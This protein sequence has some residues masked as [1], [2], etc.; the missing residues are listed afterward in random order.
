MPGLLLPGLLLLG[1][2][3]RKA[4]DLQVYD[5]II[6]SAKALAKICKHLPPINTVIAMPKDAN[7]ALSDAKSAS[8]RVMAM[9][10][11]S[12]RYLMSVAR[13]G[14]I[15]AASNE[16]NIAQ[17]AVSR[18][19]QA[20]EYQLGTPLFERKPRG[21]ALTEAGELLYSFC[22]NSTFAIERLYSEIDELKG[23]RRGRVR[24][25]SMESAVPSVLC[26]AI[27]AFRL[28]HPD[29]VFYVDIWTSDK[30][31]EAVRE[32]DVDIGLTF[33]DEFSDE[34]QVAYNA[35]EPLLAT[36]SPGHP[37]AQCKSLTIQELVDWPLALTPPRS[38]SRVIF[39]RAC[40]K[41]GI[42]I[43]PALETNSIELMHRFALGGAGVTLLIRHAAMS[44][45]QTKDLCAVPV[46]G[47]DL[48][49]NVSIITLKDRQLPLAAERFLLTIRDE[50]VRLPYPMVPSD[51]GR[52]SA[53]PN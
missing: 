9:L 14:S 46:I 13:H 15:R 51:A 19:L 40:A 44:S 43:K 35:R 41:A 48:G 33:G 38:S 20:L 23:L 52:A 45:F 12:L 21:V 6:Y 29:I 26:H 50:L 24:I 27:D 10:K 42:V 16:L 5:F 36:M 28:K 37:L 25:A 7:M 53:T 32:G 1:P 4:E 22:L 47:D 31:L 34:I 49:G 30:I 2:A 17:S 18:R 39:D 11:T 8:H 3:N